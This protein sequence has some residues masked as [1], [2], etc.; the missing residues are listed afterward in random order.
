[1]ASKAHAEVPELGQ[2]LTAI[3]PTAPATLHVMA[4]IKRLGAAPLGPIL[5]NA[6]TAIGAQDPKTALGLAGVVADYCHARFYDGHWRSIDVGWREVFW[7][8]CTIQA[9]ILGSMRDFGLR[10]ITLCVSGWNRI[11]AQ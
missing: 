3:T 2:L 4:T 1:M 7:F 11:L 8:A 5:R 10:Y 9:S 6:V